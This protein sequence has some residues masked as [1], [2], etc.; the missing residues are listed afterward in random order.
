MLE[1]VAVHWQGRRDSSSCACACAP[2]DLQAASGPGSL[3]AAGLLPQQALLWVEEESPMHPRERKE[4][5]VP[6]A[7]PHPR[8]HGLG[9]DAEPQ[10]LSRQGG[11]LLRAADPLSPG[12]IPQ[13]GRRPL[14]LQAQARPPPLARTPGTQ[15]CRQGRLR[16]CGALVSWCG[17]LVPR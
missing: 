9:C 13:P 5:L 15:S 4:V 10:D 3:A 12:P 16:L 2:Q 7:A 14:L 6:H 8:V 17:P 1:E 11:S